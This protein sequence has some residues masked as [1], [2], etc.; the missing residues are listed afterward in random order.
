MR[1][2]QSFSWAGK[3]PTR[4]RIKKKPRGGASRWWGHPGDR[5]RIRAIYRAANGNFTMNAAKPQK[6]E[7]T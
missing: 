7:R 5:E 2:A 1:G 4:E 6:D 3:K